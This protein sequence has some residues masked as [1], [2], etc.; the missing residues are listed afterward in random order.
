LSQGAGNAEKDTGELLMN[1][2][3]K[4]EDEFKGGKDA[5]G[6]IMKPAEIEYILMWCVQ[7][8]RDDLL[9]AGLTDQQ[10]KADLRRIIN[11]TLT[12]I[13]SQYDTVQS[14]SR[15][16]N[17][18]TTGDKSKSPMCAVTKI[19]G[20]E[21]TFWC[22]ILGIK[23]QIDIVAHGTLFDAT[24][25]LPSTSSSSSSSSSQ[26]SSFIGKSFF[27]PLEIKTGKHSAHAVTKARAQVILYILSLLIRERTDV[28][29][30][31]RLVN[32]IKGGKSN[33]FPANSKYPLPCRFG[34][35]L[36][37]TGEKVAVENICPR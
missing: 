28:S 19:V 27:L 7:A 14:Q 33:V 9:A 5:T 25:F 16:T 24:S 8:H 18:K 3:E 13:N 1:T 21:E 11:P 22:P 26:A 32:S 4:R 30:A 29:T 6:N 37:I 35:V 31:I 2:L 20:V 15:S 36:F 23:G 12:W 17:S 34:V 10:A